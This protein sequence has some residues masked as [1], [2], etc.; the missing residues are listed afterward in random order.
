[1]AVALFEN[2]RGSAA[3]DLD[4]CHL[5]GI[6]RREREL[7]CGGG[8][9][10]QVEESAASPATS[11][12]RT[13]LTSVARL[14]TDAGATKWQRR[15]PED[16]TGSSTRKPAAIANSATRAKFEAG[17][18]RGARLDGDEIVIADEPVHDVDAE[19]QVAGEAEVGVGE[20][21]ARCR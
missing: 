1:M 16:A 7:G 3:L 20:E 2:E 15:W 4:P 5:L 12:A 11:R 14:M 8:S 17:V 18:D 19:I 9:G 6:E 13:T 21:S 10:S